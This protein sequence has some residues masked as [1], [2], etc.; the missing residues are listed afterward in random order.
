VKRFKIDRRNK[1]YAC[2]IGLFVKRWWGWKELDYFA[3]VADARKRYD[4]IKDLPEYL[5]ESP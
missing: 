1:S 4:E 2:P 3:T 5:D